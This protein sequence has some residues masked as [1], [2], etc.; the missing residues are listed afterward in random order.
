M[1][2]LQEDFYSNHSTQTRTVPS[3]FQPKHVIATDE[4]GYKNWFWGGISSAVPELYFCLRINVME[5]MDMFL[6]GCCIDDGP[7]KII[8]FRLIENS[9]LKKLGSDQCCY[10]KADYCIQVKLFISMPN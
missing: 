1:R 6:F 4:I 3:T 9:A 8:P 5:I 7:T 2:E 10:Y